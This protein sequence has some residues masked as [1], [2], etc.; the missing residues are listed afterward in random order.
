LRRGRT[1]DL[2]WK[3]MRL[4]Q[5]VSR[6]RDHGHDVQKD[7]AGTHVAVHEEATQHAWEVVEGGIYKYTIV[8]FPTW[9]TLHA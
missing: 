5:G 3:E 9:A 6:Q 4:D 8:F 2:G 1:A 7:T